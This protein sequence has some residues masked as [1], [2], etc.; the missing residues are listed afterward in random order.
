M[1]GHIF[2]LITL[3]IIFKH[4][5]NKVEWFS[6][7]SKV[8]RMTLIVLST[9]F[10]VLYF[11]FGILS[12]NKGISVVSLF[13]IEYGLFFVY[14]TYRLLVLSKAVD[15]QTKFSNT[16]HHIHSE[17]ISNQHNAIE[18]LIKDTMICLEDEDFEKAY[19]LIDQVETQYAVDQNI[20]LLKTIV[21]Q[22]LIKEDLDYAHTFCY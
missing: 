15:Y 16:E 1:I 13:K 3:V 8:K 2:S 22:S 14:A 7:R 12:I 19:L 11:I 17:Q 5:R 6:E 9:L 20:V 18:K 4:L 10:S 21:N